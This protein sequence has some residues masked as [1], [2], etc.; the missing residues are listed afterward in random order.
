M[1]VCAMSPW[2]QSHLGGQ[3]NGVLCHPSL[4]HVWQQQ[5]VFSSWNHWSWHPVTSAELVCGQ[6]LLVTSTVKQTGWGDDSV[7]AWL[8][9]LNL[10]FLAFK[11][12]CQVD[13]FLLCF[14]RKC[15]TIKKKRFCG[16]RQ[17]WN[18]FASIQAQQ[19]FV[20]PERAV[21]CSAAWWPTLGCCAFPWARNSVCA[22]FQTH[23][24]LCS[25]PSAALHAWAK[26]WTS[27]AREK[28]VLNCFKIRLHLNWGLEKSPWVFQK[29]VGF[30]LG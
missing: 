16:M 23:S 4:T 5:A 20:S 29:H 13:G 30:P 19:W 12:F 6:C 8:L 3:F 27:N 14:H 17:C 15:P 21:V 10:F 24:P 2:W 26:L 18:Y 25:Q 1:A 11:L 9:L 22:A 7:T 28:A